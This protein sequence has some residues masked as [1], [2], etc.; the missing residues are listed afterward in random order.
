MVLPDTNELIKGLNGK[1]NLWGKL[2]FVWN[3]A[4]VK[5]TR[6]RAVIMGT[7]EKFRNMG[8]ESAMFMKLQEYTRPL[9]H[10][11]ELELSWVGDFN[12]KML[13][14]H[15]AIGATFS[16]KHATMFYKFNN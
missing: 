8:L 9:D 15:H 1:L 12:S 14:V 6:M 11:K 10:Y 4:T 16:K 13:S 2:R 5:H 7:K 3:K